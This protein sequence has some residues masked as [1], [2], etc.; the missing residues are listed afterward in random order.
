MALLEFRRSSHVSGLEARRSCRGNSCYRLHFHDTFSIG[1]IQEGRSTLTGALDGPIGLE[2][3][4]VVV[5]PAGHVHAC[6]PEKGPWLYHMIH[7]NQQWAYSRIAEGM[8]NDIFS[9]IRLLRDSALP[10]LVHAFSRAIFEDTS[11]SAIEEHANKLSQ[12]MS[13]ITPAILAK[14]TVDGEL[15]QKLEPVLARLKDDASMPPLNELAEE[16]HMSKYQLVRAMRKATGLTPVAW[17]H[18]ARIIEAR[19]L[20]SE[21]Q[22]IAQIAHVLGFTDQSHFHRVFRAYVAASPG[23][24]RSQL[25]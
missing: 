15:V 7:T 8:G 22:P 21:G 3:G 24:Y 13:R 12:A 11:K 1:L 23:R 10:D 14:N 25:Q 19:H 5:I 18:N 9:G 2:S 16:V 4:D 6:N 20:L 17:R